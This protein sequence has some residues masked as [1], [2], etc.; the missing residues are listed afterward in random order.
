MNIQ[1]VIDRHEAFYRSRAAQTVRDP[2]TQT[3]FAFLAD[4]LVNI[5]YS[6]KVWAIGL[7]PSALGLTCT[8]FNTLVH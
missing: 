1:C 4:E 2:Q 5:E 6:H 7:I 8:N 3:E